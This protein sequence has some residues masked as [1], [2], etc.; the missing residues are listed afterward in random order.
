MTRKAIWYGY[1]KAGKK[2]SP[3]V[4]DTKL[5][6]RNPKTIYLFNYV[7]GKFLEY[8]RELVEPKLHDL[9]PDDNL[10][11]ELKIAFKAARKMFVVDQNTQKIVTAAAINDIQTT[12]L[13]EV[14]NIPDLIQENTIDYVNASDGA[15]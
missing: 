2:S 3:V 13:Y 4:L 14:G 9:D 15:A 10:L 8:S 7:R 6:T 5:Q 11:K 1:L 12:A